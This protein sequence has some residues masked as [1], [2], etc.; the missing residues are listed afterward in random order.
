MRHTRWLRAR[1][2]DEVQLSH[3]N[4]TD[5]ITRARFCEIGTIL[6]DSSTLLGVFFGD[7]PKRLV[8][9]NKPARF[10]HQKSLPLFPFSGACPTILAVIRNAPV[11]LKNVTRVQ[12]S[13]RYVQGS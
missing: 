7:A 2:Y 12:H 8:P 10:L 9:Y 5:W 6:G 4:V 11:C 13:G 1:R 3:Y